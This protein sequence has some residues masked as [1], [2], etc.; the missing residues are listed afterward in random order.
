[1]KFES[2]NFVTIQGWMRTELGLKGNDLLVYAAIY[3][4]SQKDGQWFTGG[5]QYLADLCGSSLRGVQKNLERLAHAGLIEVSF[6]ES[7]ARLNRYR[8]KKIYE[9]SSHNYQSTRELSSYN[10]ELSSHNSQDG[11]KIGELS[12]ETHEL[13]SSKHA[14][15]VRTEYNNNINNNINNSISFDKNNKNKKSINSSRAREEEFSPLG[16][17]T[18]EQIEQIIA[19]WNQNNTTK[20]ISRIDR[21][22]TRENNTRLCIGKVGFSGFIEV[23]EKMDLQAWFQKRRR[24]GS[25]I[26]YD[27]FVRP[28]NFVKTLEGNYAEEWKKKDESIVDE[29]REA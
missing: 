14:N 27:W 26:T 28:D 10:D 6:V 22:S 25:Q 15:S 17:L 21:L 8:A 29:W 2:E 11:E 13:S 1:M 20:K 9:H 24:D 16:E 12:S 5:Q 18:K 3:G 7:N 4:F 23:V 19:A